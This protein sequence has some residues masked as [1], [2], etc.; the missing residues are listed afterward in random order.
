MSL[1]Q[2]AWTD[3][4]VNGLLILTCTVLQTS[5]E[6]DAYTLKTPARTIDGTIPWNLFYWASATADGEAMPI[7]IWLG[8]EDN[9][10]LS[11]Q[12]ASLVAVN[13]GMYKQ[14]LDDGVLAI[15]NFEY[16]HL[17]DPNLRKADVV[18]VAAIASGYKA[19]IPAAPYYAFNID[20]G[21]TLNDSITM[22]WRIVQQQ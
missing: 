18:T 11:G 9:F 5:T 21:S 3:S 13:G 16:G 10:A 12:G 6:T 14:I 7:D 4:S 8:Y 22:N 15:V 1:T 19:N 17:F 20:G 2:S